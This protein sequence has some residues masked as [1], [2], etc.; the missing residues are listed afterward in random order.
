MDTLPSHF[1]HV[2]CISAS[3]ANGMAT[4]LPQPRA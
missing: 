3:L 2:R 1:Q 4:Y